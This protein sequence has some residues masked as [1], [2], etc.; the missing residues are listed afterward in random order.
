MKNILFYTDTPQIG[1]AELQI[2][3]LAKF[4]NKEKFKPILVCSNF[5][6]LDGW[7]TK[8]EKEE[9]EVIR[10]NVKNKHDFKHLSKLKKIIKEKEIDLLHIHVWNPASCR[11]AF[12]AGSQTKTPIITTE[13]DPFKLNII[14]NLF[15]KYTLNKIS[16]IV[17]ISENNKKLLTKLYPKHKNKIAMIH[18]GIDTT[19]W[20]SQLIRFTDKDRKKIKEEIFYAKENTLIITCIAE[21]HERKGQKFLIEAIPEI[22]KEYPNL[23]FVFIGEGKNRENLEKLVK[24]LK[25][26]RNV[27]FTGRQDA[28]PKLLKSSDIFVLPS[29]REAFGLVN[30]EAMLIPLP[31]VASKVG[32]IP[33]IIKDGK[34]GSL[35]QAEKPQELTKALKRLISSPEKRKKMALEGHKRILEK[36]DAKVMAKSYE[37]IYK[38]ILT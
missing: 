36:F 32:G 38:E 16:K 15:K 1:G 31:I 6:Q 5:R 20:K 22:T 26:E 13:H 24:K 34:T 28:I 23:K 14:K 2:Y 30:L 35:V 33:E 4:L 18:N 37:K 21:L 19:W 25:A 9:I 11:F 3:L 8:F 7:C 29:K 10:L 27:T 17:T 12:L